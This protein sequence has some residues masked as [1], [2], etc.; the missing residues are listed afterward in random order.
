MALFDSLTSYMI[1]KTLQQNQPLKE[2]NNCVN[3]RQMKHKCSICIDICP[4][5]VYKSPNEK[6]PNFTECRNC[7]LCV[8]A[9]P[10]RCITSSAFNTKNYID[11]L[12]SEL[13]TVY[14][15]CKN[16]NGLPSIKVECFST[17]PWELIACLCLRKKVV[18]LNSGCQGCESELAPDVWNTTLEKLALF[19]GKTLK[20][21]I[22]FS[23][24]S[25]FIIKQE[26]T[27]R[28]LFN[29]I[30]KKS[31]SM[32]SIILPNEK[33]MDGLL[34]RRI[35]RKLIEDSP[36]PINFK[37]I[38]PMVNDKCEGCPICSRVCPTSALQLLKTED[39][40][41]LI[42]KPSLCNN[43]GLCEKTCIHHAITGYGAITLNNFKPL[44]L[45]KKK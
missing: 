37:W 36:T 1:N 5:K 15:G 10:S 31:K 7:N 33:D 21:H 6:S 3:A 34:Y 16:Y 35:L 39:S 22:V 23:N 17:L 45:H 18:F 20:E 32:L 25:N 41:Q 11:I 40:F 28:E 43:C 27:R 8:A 14:I 9:C 12:N 2:S 26:I 29:D 44:L 19:F 24:D 30:K 42:F 13:D 38:I 4:E